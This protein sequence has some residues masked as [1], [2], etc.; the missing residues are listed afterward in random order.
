MRRLNHLLLVSLTVLPAVSEGKSTMTDTTGILY[1]SCLYDKPAELS[2]TYAQL[3]VDQAKNTITTGLDCATSEVRINPARIS[4]KC[5]DQLDMT[6]DRL[7]GHF[8]ATVKPQGKAS[9]F[10]TKQKGPRF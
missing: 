9:G 8:L 1:L 7:N 6:V 2:G 10:C 4:F 3:I 5:G